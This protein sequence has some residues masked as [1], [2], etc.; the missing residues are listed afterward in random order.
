MKRL[1]MLAA[2]A[3][4]MAT[5]APQ[6]AAA[7]R[8]RGFAVGGGGL[9]VA[10]VGGYRGAYGLRGGYGLRS[11]AF[12]P[13]YG[14]RAGLWRPGLGYAAGWRW[15]YPLAAGI[16]AASYYGGYG[17]YGYGYDYGYGYGGYDYGY[18]YGYAAGYRDPCIISDG[19][20]Y[21][22]VSVCTGPYAYRYWW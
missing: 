10:A 3:L 9:R 19:Y 13:R 7:Q 22:A 4:V 6:E 1:M 20:G 17:G 11:A 8:G 14:I 16:V 5:L 2:A 18:G 21:Q 12:G 15:G